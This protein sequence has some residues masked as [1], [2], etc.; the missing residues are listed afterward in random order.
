M[1]ILDY[2]MFYLDF[3]QKLSLTEYWKHP[4][5]CFV[6]KNYILAS[7]DIFENNKKQFIDSFLF[8]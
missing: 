5:L 6:L 3:T 8:I 2:S 1:T 4:F 7:S